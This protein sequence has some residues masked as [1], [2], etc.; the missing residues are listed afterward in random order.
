[1]S[2]VGEDEQYVGTRSGGVMAL[3][4]SCTACDAIPEPETATFG[5]GTITFAAGAGSPCANLALGQGESL[6]L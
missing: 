4:Q 1:M 6:R 3:T 2:I 5:D